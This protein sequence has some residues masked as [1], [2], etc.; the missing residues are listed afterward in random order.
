MMKMMKQHGLSV[1]RVA[2]LAMCSAALVAAAPAMAQGG[3]G[4]GQ[5]GGGM[6]TQAQVDR[7]TAALTLTADQQTSIKAILDQ[8][9]KDNMAL[10][11]DTSLSDDDRRAKM[12]DM[13]KAQQDKIKAVL[14]ADQKPKYDDY[15]KNQP[16]RG[17]GGPPPPP[18]AL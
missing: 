1:V 14:T 12:M 15:L 11:A 10:R 4:G 16:Q 9:M 6:N 17:P 18:P 5:R 7:L 13:R 8:S 2:L 3:G